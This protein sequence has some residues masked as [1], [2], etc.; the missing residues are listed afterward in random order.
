[1]ANEGSNDVS[2]LF[3]QGQGREWTFTL[4]PRVEVDGSGPVAT[5]VVPDSTGDGIPELL[6]TN[7]TSNNVNLFN[8]RR[9]GLLNERER[10]ARSVGD[11]PQQS[12]VGFFDDIP[13]PD[14][15]AINSR[16][17]D[18]SFLSDFANPSS[19]GRR[20]ATGGQTP[21]AGLAGDFNADGFGDLFVAHNGDGVIALLL[22]GLG[23]LSL[24]STVT[25]PDLEH[26]TAIALAALGI[27]VADEGE[28]EVSLFTLAFDFGIAVL[29]PGDE[30][31]PTERPD[32][33]PL[34]ESDLAVVAVL[35]T[36]GLG[37]TDA[38]RGG[39][40]PSDVDVVPPA[41]PP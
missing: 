24:A 34:S 28:E 5:T 27:A 1:V 40:T 21:L 39:T 38:G 30:P 20:I 9:D 29:P 3:G 31:E 2:I 16:S 7:S 23:G 25:R 15:V 14:L 35:L 26:P 10:I 6:V 37:D 41:T 22:G 19:T 32:F 12:I 11:G 8:G 36:D 13:G 17:N 18:I 33:L 4:G